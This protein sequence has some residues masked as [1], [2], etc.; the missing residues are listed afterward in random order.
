MRRE[1]RGVGARARVVR[2]WD[3]RREAQGRGKVFCVCGGGEFVRGQ[4][5]AG[6]G[7]TI[8]CPRL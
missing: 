7:G 5:R 8:I 1:V 6:Q 2:G 3:A 4:G